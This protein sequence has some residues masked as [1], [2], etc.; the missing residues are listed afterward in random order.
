MAKKSKKK[1]APEEPAQMA[2]GRTTG[3]LVACA[4]TI[5]G[6]AQGVSLSHLLFRAAVGSVIVCLV[7]G[8]FARLVSAMA[9]DTD[10]S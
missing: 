5:V 10:A 6:A 8:M 9:A 2:W 4:A 7:V 3:L 1:T